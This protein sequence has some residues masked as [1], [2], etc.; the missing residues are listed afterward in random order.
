[1][2]A[3]KLRHKLLI[4]TNTPSADSVTGE[5]VKSWATTWTAYGEIIAVTGGEKWLANTTSPDLTHVIN[6]RGHSSV[7]ITPSMRILFGTRVF[8]ILRAQNM[9]E[10]DKRWQIQCREIVEG[11]LDG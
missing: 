5:P 2:R 6:V 1:M 9:S 4:Q 10:I 11:G 3:G 7:D 8:E